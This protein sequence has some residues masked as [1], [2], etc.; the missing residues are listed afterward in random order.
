M[1][2]ASRVSQTP[3]LDTV[4]GGLFGTGMV[5][6]VIPGFLEEVASAPT[7]EEQ[8]LVQ[9]VMDTVLGFSFGSLAMSSAPAFATASGVALVGE[10]IFDTLDVL[11]TMAQKVKESGRSIQEQKAI[12]K[13]FGP[14]L[15]I[16]NETLKQLTQV[17]QEKGVQWETSTLKLKDLEKNYPAH[18]D[19]LAIVSQRITFLQAVLPELMSQNK[20]TIFGQRALA[21]R[22]ELVKQITEEEEEAT[23]LMKEL[24]ELTQ[25]VGEMVI[26]LEHFEAKTA[27]SAETK[28][29]LIS[30]L[31]GDVESL[32]AQQALAAKTMNRPSHVNVSIASY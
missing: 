13:S 1:S 5:M 28:G 31:Q 26:K 2:T 3:P 16:T 32:I 12:I 8:S 30:G 6:S 21:S 18:A 14:I 7:T 4:S 29:V 22:V 10:K 25:S 11:F 17:A 19:L 24:T 15:E 20:I 23:A 9:R 27:E